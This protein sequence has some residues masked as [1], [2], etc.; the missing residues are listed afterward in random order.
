MKIISSVL[1]LVVLI[2]YLCQSNIVRGDLPVHCEF[3]QIKGDWIFKL[4]QN[5]L[6]KDIV[7]KVPITA[8]I[9]TVRTLSL[10]LD[11]PATVR[12]Q[13][14]N[15]GF[16][17]LVYDQGFEIVFNDVK[18]FAF[19]NY[20]QDGE[21]VISNCDRTFTGW[22]HNVGVNPTNWG[23]F[24][25][26]KVPSASNKFPTTNV[27]EIAKPLKLSTQTTKFSNDLKYI[28]QINKSQKSWIAKAYPQFEGKSIADLIRMGGRRVTKA[29]RESK[30]KHVELIRLIN[31]S[32]MTSSKRSSINLPESFDWRNVSS[33][34]INY[35]SPVRNQ[36]SCGSCYIF[37]SMGMLE[38][39]TRIMSQLRDLSVYSP[40]EIVSCSKYSQGCDGGFPYLIGKYSEDFGVVQ[41][42]CYPYEAKDTDCKDTSQCVRQY[43]TNYYYVGGFYGASTEENMQEEIYR[44][45]PIV[46]GIE[47]YPD[48]MHYSGGVYHHTSLTAQ[49]D[50]HFEITNHAVVVVGWGVTESNEKYWIVKN[51]WGESWGLNGYVLIRK[52]SDEIDI[53]SEAVAAQPTN[54]F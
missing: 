32:T 20:T 27:H 21:K 9:T 42:K 33:L 5:G 34:N 25:A 35:V 44:N 6:T 39:R 54:I 26:I 31:K 14:G 15:T 38:S 40:Q 7:N 16:W 53:E 2:G 47:V 13:S 28:D 49:I 17:T 1:L 48:F 45:G 19:F 12:D 29:Q 30:K 3:P 22:Y 46:V 24:R 8:P 36:Q 51:S 18:Y 23:A 50:P 4:G 10:S 11:A 43:G 37:A 41:E 52:G